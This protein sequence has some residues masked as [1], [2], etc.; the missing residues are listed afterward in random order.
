MEGNMSKPV[1]MIVPA[2]RFMGVKLDDVSFHQVDRLIASHINSGGYVCMN[3]VRNVMWAA[4]DS[5][6]REAINSSF[7][8]L[9]DG[10]P[11]VWYARLTGCGNIERVTGLKILS[12]LL[13]AKN[14]FRHFL[15]GDTSSR[16]GLVM[17][18][19]RRLN[20]LISI[21]GYSPPFKKFFTP[22]DNNRILDQIRDENPDLIW[23]SLGGGKQEKWMHQHYQRLEKGIMVGVGAAFRFYIGELVTPPGLFQSFGLQWIWRM[24]QDT[25]G[26][27][28]RGRS[29]A[30]GVAVRL[31]FLRR[32]PRELYKARRNGRLC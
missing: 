9:P 32:F 19:A 6:L 30:Q 10:M 11:L 1:E 8:S 7:L 5:E 3:D 15:L 14:G 25:E 4:R 28:R 17:E 2:C 31:Q 16:I 23:V 12:G 27:S 20:P 26:V 24:T 22:E 18:K 29:R 21:T 13:K